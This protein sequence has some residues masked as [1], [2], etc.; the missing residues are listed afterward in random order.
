MT[1]RKHF[2]DSTSCRE[3]VQKKIVP[4][5]VVHLFEPH[6]KKRNNSTDINRMVSVLTLI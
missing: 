1:C 2:I 4:P 5:V 3:T 6:V